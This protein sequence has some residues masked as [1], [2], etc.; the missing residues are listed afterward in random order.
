[1]LGFSDDTIGVVHKQDFERGLFS[2]AIQVGPGIVEGGQLDISE[3]D[4]QRP[5]YFRSILAVC[6][7]TLLA[8]ISTRPAHLRTLGQDPLTYT[9]QQNLLCDEVVNLAGDRQ[10]ILGLRTDQGFIYHGDPTTYK[11]S[12][13]GFK[14]K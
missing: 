6:D 10:A 13:I 11:V 12:L 3:A 4:L 2:S 5:K 1:M 8:G 7:Q 9:Q 14:K